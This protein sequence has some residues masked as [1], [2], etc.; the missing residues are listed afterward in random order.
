MQ[1]QEL[2][3]DGHLSSSLCGRSKETLSNVRVN[4]W[5]GT[6]ASNPRFDLLELWTGLKQDPDEATTTAYV[7]FKGRLSAPLLI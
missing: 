7:S 6:D 2:G 5:T 4:V 3:R 1:V